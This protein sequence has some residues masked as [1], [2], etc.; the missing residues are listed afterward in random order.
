[1]FTYTYTSVLLKSLSNGQSR[2]ICSAH[3]HPR[4]VS[5]MAK[6]LD[7]KSRLVDDF[8]SRANQNQFTFVCRRLNLE[9]ALSAFCMRKNDFCAHSKRAR[10]RCDANLR[11]GRLKTDE[12]Q[13]IGVSMANGGRLHRGMHHWWR[14]IPWT[15]RVYA[16]PL[17]A[18]ARAASFNFIYIIHC[19]C[20]RHYYY[21][22]PLQI[23]Y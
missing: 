2:T 20:F 12:L 19:Y 22:T 7:E 17:S 8:G 16:S 6:T 4:D 14:N 23:V 5:Q 10:F 11:K 9:G 18:L 13:P 21:N 15:S 3:T 1:M